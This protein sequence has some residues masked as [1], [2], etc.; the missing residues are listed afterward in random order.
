MLAVEQPIP[1]YKFPGAIGWN[2]FQRGPDDLP[3]Q[4]TKARASSS[5]QCA[6]KRPATKSEQDGE[7]LDAQGGNREHDRQR[8]HPGGV[9]LTRLAFDRSLAVGHEVART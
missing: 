9:V 7:G 6:S 1:Y 3:P 2:I 4:A 5:R 8:F